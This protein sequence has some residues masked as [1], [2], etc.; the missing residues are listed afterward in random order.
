MLLCIKHPN[1][2]FLA[3]QRI[4]HIDIQRL[5][6]QIPPTVD[7]KFLWCA[8]SPSLLSPFDKM[9]TDYWRQISSTWSSVLKYWSMSFADQLLTVIAFALELMPIPDVLDTN[10]TH[11]HTSS[12]HMA[13]NSYTPNH[14]FLVY[15]FIFTKYVLNTE[16]QPN[17]RCPKRS[18]KFPFSDVT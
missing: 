14:L 5:W 7:I 3:S 12:Q 13:K 11:T 9:S 8:R 15:T 10:S 2:C 4:R 17:R 6:V 1:E 16:F 18:F